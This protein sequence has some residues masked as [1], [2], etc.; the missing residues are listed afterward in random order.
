MAFCESK[1]IYL[2]MDDIYHKLVFDKVIAPP[3]YN[4]TKQD[5]DNSH[6]IVVNGVA[7]LYG[8][9]GYRIGWTIAPRR[10]V[11]VMINVQSN[12]T[13]CPSV[14]SQAAAEAAL[15]GT[16]S[17]V[18]NLR[19]TIQNNRDIFLQEMRS[20]SDVTTIKP[21]GTFYALPDFRAYSNKSVDLAR[22]ILNKAM[23]VTVP[24]AEFGMEGY[25]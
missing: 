11:E 14:V 8:M 16:Q 9:T 5:V 18:D 22:F 12:V 20:F 1:G 6:V 23:V 4:F 24:G 25:P 7:K 13:S 17:V 15:T 21:D 2:I 3:A 10:M 19:L